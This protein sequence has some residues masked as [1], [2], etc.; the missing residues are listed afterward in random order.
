MGKKILVVDDDDSV[1]NLVRCILD[2]AGYQVVVAASAAEALAVT[3]GEESF[4]LL[5]SDIV[6]PGGDGIQLAYSLQQRNPVLRVILMSGYNE[7]LNA[8]DR[9]WICLRKPFHA[10][11]L[12]AA[13]QQVMG[14]AGCPG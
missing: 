11:E 5:V 4:D 1:R 6:M 10:D 13:I 2:L 14:Q 7:E 12:T 3:S 9:R 8:P